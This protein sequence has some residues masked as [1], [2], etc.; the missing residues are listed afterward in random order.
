MAISSTEGRITLSREWPHPVAID[1]SQLTGL[2]VF[3]N[4]EE[5]W[6][7]DY[8]TLTAP[9][10]LP[11]DTLATGYANCPDGHGFWPGTTLGPAGLHRTNDAAAF[12]NASD[13]AAFF[14]SAATTG[15]TASVDAYIRRDGLDRC[16]FY[17]SEIAALN[18]G[19]TGLLPMKPIEFGVMVLGNRYDNVAYRALLADTATALQGAELTL[20]QQSIADL[21]QV[22]TQAKA[23]ERIADNTEI[24]GWKIQCD[25]IDVLFDED[26]GNL[27][28]SAIGEEFGSSVSGMATGQGSFRGELAN[29]WD[30][31]ELSAVMMLRLLRMKRK[32]AAAT[33]RIQI[34]RSRVIPVGV[35]AGPGD[36]L[37]TLSGDVLITL[38]GDVLTTLGAPTSGG[39]GRTR[40]EFPI[41]YETKI[42]FG[43]TTVGIT[44]QQNTSFSGDFVSTGDI[45]MVTDPIEA[46]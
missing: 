2:R 46:S 10:G 35:S 33:A 38:G 19:A 36:R 7:G 29:D 16:T 20:G 24:R 1:D 9:G 25:L 26:S 23:I 40:Q 30:S 17:T 22:R 42:L 41:Y 8:V 6:T 44:A 27:D 12:Y 34:A 43:K 3:V 4:E 15:L 13:S 18:G 32:G 39:G 11:F 31:G 37:T 14:D 21:P 5:F 45:K 28:M